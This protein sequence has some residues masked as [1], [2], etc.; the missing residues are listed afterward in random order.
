[1][2]LDP[3]H[4]KL[5]LATGKL[6]FLCSTFVFQLFW[7][8]LIHL[9]LLEGNED[10]WNNCCILSKPEGKLRSKRK[11]IYRISQIIDCHN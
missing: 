9:F 6:L 5:Q 1:M 4:Q 7:Q 3:D 11:M 10:R 2:F 8:L